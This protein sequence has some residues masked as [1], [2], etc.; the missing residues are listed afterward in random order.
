[1]SKN[2]NQNAANEYVD[3]Q[4]EKTQKQLNTTRVVSIIMIIFVA[5]Y[6]GCITSKLN[7]VVEPNELSDTLLTYAESM[8]EEEGVSRINELQAKIP[9]LIQQ[10]IPELIMSQIK[11]MMKRLQIQEGNATQRM[12]TTKVG[13]FISKAL[14]SFLVDRKDAVEQYFDEISKMNEN[15]DPAEKA[16]HK[17]KADQV[18]EG[19]SSSFNETLRNMATEEEFQTQ[20]MSKRFKSSLRSLKA[21]N[22]DIAAYTRPFDKLSSEER[23]IRYGIALILDQA[24]WATDANPRRIG[25]DLENPLEGL[26]NP[27]KKPEK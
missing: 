27:F 20:L 25:D 4:L 14:K 11:P 18:M 26:K 17:A 12:M 21:I 7:K 3:E 8:L 24:K 23:D 15:I 19:I 10:K 22:S 9:E 2:K 13:P 16:K 5:T 6:M 1:M